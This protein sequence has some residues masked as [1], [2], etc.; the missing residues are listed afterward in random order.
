MST[1]TDR[2]I[3]VMKDIDGFG[4]VERDKHEY[5]I[6]A[7]HENGRDEPTK[8]DELQGIRMLIDAAIAYEKLKGKS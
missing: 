5:A 8:E 6:F 3:F 2:L 1:D 4:S 7:A